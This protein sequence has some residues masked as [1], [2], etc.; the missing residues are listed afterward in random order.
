M[1]SK[2]QMQR[3]RSIVKNFKSITND[4]GWDRVCN[5]YPVIETIQELV[6]DLLLSIKKEEKLL[7]EIENH[8]LWV[9]YRDYKFKVWL[10]AERNTLVGDIL[11]NDEIDVIGLESDSL[12]HLLTELERQVDNQINY[13][14]QNQLAEENIQLQAE[15]EKWKKE[16]IYLNKMIGEI[17][18]EY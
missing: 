14:Y 15:V 3:Y 2:K 17:D 11:L 8:I 5:E 13:K 4:D 10:D 16:V 1:N 18:D 7:S 6:A 9:D 12:T